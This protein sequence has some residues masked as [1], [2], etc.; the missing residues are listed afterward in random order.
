M[1]FLQCSIYVLWYTWHCLWFLHQNHDCELKD[2]HWILRL[3]FQYCQRFTFSWGQ[4]GDQFVVW[5]LWGNA[6]L[7]QPGVVAKNDDL[8]CLWAPMKLPRLRLSSLAK[9]KPSQ[10]TGVRADHWN[11]SMTGLQAQWWGGRTQCFGFGGGWDG[12][13]RKTRVAVKTGGQNLCIW[14]F[15]EVFGWAESTHSSDT[16][17]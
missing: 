14:K 4:R 17:C 1:Y 6:A 9:M 15:H 13:G 7:R 10:F 5:G 12:H 16:V 8:V 11:W 3:T 2:W